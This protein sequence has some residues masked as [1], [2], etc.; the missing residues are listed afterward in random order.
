MELHDR[1]LKCFQAGSVKYWL[2][3]WCRLTQDLEV[4]ETVTGLP[5][6]R[7]KTVDIKYASAKNILSP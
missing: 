6:L 7:K 4:L 2:R 3:N 1:V 5:I